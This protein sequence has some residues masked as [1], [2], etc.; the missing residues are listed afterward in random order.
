MTS[1]SWGC[2]P[3]PPPSCYIR[4]LRTEK[5]GSLGRGQNGKFS[6]VCTPNT[7]YLSPKPPFP[8]RYAKGQLKETS[9]QPPMGLVEEVQRDLKKKKSREK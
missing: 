6:E 2:G 4:K 5:G 3:K 9:R 1:R 7:P 8:L